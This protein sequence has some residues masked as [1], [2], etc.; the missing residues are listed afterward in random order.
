MV[1]DRK[2]RGE[3]KTWEAGMSI[4]QDAKRIVE[5]VKQGLGRYVKKEIE[6]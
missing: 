3:E 1:Y 6:E 2:V 5:R 4:W